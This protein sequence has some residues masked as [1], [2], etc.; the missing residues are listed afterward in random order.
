MIS[1]LRGTVALID[2]EGI[3]LEVGGVGLQVF[4]PGG[5]KDRLQIGDAVFL[6]TRLIV[7]QELLALYG[8]ET[9]EGR[10]FFDLLLGVN[11]IGPRLALAIIST[12]NPDVIRRA[13]FDDQLD[14]FCR[15]PGVGKKSAQKIMLHLQ[16]RLPTGGIA[17][18]LGALSDIDTE[19]L[20]ALTALGYSVVEGQ[21]AIQYLPKDAPMDLE[22]RLRLA[23]QY[24][25]R[26]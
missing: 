11:G 12:L 5:L 17:A 4:V 20:A 7:R 25:S 3:V 16:D 1:L 26:P 8:F 18:T 19:V 21:A 22:E 9:K 14:V 15:V 10:E 23:L 2:N 6:Y 13:V 24:F